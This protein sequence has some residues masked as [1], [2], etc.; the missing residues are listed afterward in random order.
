MPQK[1][2]K[3]MFLFTKE[4]VSKLGKASVSDFHSVCEQKDSQ[5]T[6]ALLNGNQTPEGMKAF[7]ETYQDVVLVAADTK[8]G[9]MVKAAHENGIDVLDSTR[10]AKI[11][12]NQIGCT[13]V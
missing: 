7:M 4:A 1:D 3:V 10:T 8:G 6:Y 2:T 13:L 11:I 5:I 12:E 9:T